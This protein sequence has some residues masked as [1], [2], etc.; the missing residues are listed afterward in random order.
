MKNHWIYLCLLSIVFAVSLQA[1]P[2]DRD[3]SSRQYDSS[4]A[5]RSGMISLFADTAELTTSDYQLAIEK[6]F[7]ILENAE[8]KGELGL[9]V[10]LVKKAM[11]DN[12]SM[13]AVLKDNLLNN[14]AALNLRNLQVFRTLLQNMQVTLREHRSVLDSAENRLGKLRLSIQP[15]MADT[16]MRQLMRDSALRIQFAAQLK[17][18]RRAFR[19]TAM[20]LRKSLSEINTLQIHVSSGVIS[21][22]QLLE[23]VNNQLTT[24]AATIF[25]KEYNY[26]WEKDT[27]RLSEQSR[28]S[29]A[30]AYRGEKKAVRYYFKDSG[31]KRLFLLLIGLIFCLW[32][33]RNIRVLN[34]HSTNALPDQLDFSYVRSGYVVSSL[35]VML[36]IAPLFDLHAPS[37]YIEMM[38]FLLL[39][40]LTIICWRKWPR[41][42]FLVWLAM[43]GLYMVFS[44]MHHIADPGYIHRFGLILLNLLSIFLGFRFLSMMKD[45]LYFKGFL[46]FVIILHNVMNALSI[47]FNIFGRF[48][49]AQLLGNAAI[50]S[51]MQVVGLAV[52]SKIC[53][54]AISMQIVTS[55]IRKGAPATF[56]YQPVLNSFRPL[57]LL[58]VSL[59]WL[60]V[61]TTNLGIYQSVFNGLHSILSTTRYIGNASFSFGGILLFFLIIWIAHLLQRYVGYFFGDTGADDEIQHK[62]QRSRLLIARLVLLCLGYLLA[63]TASGVPIDKITIVL[64]ALGVGIG[65]GLQNIVSN[66][67]SG[68]ILIFDRPLRIGDT[69]KIGDH[70]GRVKEIG[71]RSST[72]LT[73]DGAEVIIPN[74]DILS[75]QIVNWTLSDNQRRLEMNFTVH[76][77]TDMERASTFTKQAVL[78]ST[79]ITKGRE[80]QILVTKVLP[81]GFGMSVFFWCRD[82]AKSEE[83]ESEVLLLVH[84]YLEK[85]GL[86]VE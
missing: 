31:H 46:R 50:F 36:C 86:V 6:T 17:D 47:L 18:V 74:G 45:H 28:L 39:I 63:V 58:V 59:L 48:T 30:R 14:A 79:N 53:I 11:P 35:A 54:E 76:G 16:V 32:M 57:I 84:Q 26:L 56:D 10:L 69:V 42:L 61:L 21:S 73:A 78:E 65:L 15:L 34:K 72:L 71:L 29:F 66:F 27:V 64:G 8:N 12:D 9:P 81:D 44:F 3:S 51:F 23:K 85:N 20:R 38:Q 55:R 7:V 49:L 5:R 24:S 37:V 62:G 33:Y 60:V 40:L 67:V 2:R 25:G 82:V 22:T 41:K 68:I 70:S 19:S 1:Q 13:L 80:P 52:F 83:T 4:R 75:E 77:I 43:V